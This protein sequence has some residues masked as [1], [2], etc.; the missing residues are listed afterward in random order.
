MKVVI[1]EP[2]LVRSFKYGAMD[3]EDDKCL[4]LFYKLCKA[5]FKIRKHNRQVIYHNLF[6]M[7]KN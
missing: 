3:I 1:D 4:Y 2:S 5:I 6:D 7:R